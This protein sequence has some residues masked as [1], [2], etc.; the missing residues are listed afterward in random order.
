MNSFLYVSTKV[1]SSATY[2]LRDYVFQSYGY[3]YSPMQSP[4]SGIEEAPLQFGLRVEQ[5]TPLSR[6]ALINYSVPYLTHVK[7]GVYDIVGRLVLEV[8]DDEVKPGK[9]SFDWKGCDN[10]SRRVASGVYFVK[11]MTEDYEETTKIVV[12]E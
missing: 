2:P 7:I 8:V 6:I 9:H 3:Y 4:Q 12:L 10:A 11:M 5:L 1:D